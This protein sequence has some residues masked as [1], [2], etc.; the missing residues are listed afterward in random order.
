MDKLQDMYHT[1]RSM[2][3]RKAA[4]QLINLGMVVLSALMIWKGLIV[5]TSGEAPVVVVLS[6]SMETAFK[7]GDILFLMGGSTGPLKAGD[8]VVFK[9][10]GRDIPIVHRV[11]EIHVKPNGKSRILTKGDNN[12]VDDRGLYHAGQLWLSQS[13]VIGRATGYLPYVGM[14]TITLTDYPYLKYLLVG[15][16]CL[17]VLTGREE[18]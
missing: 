18:E 3:R 14:V 12:P 7:R 11:M 2:D 10:K 6:G 13:D 4:H 15:L 1:V 9:V 8:I 5:V 16:M 17:F